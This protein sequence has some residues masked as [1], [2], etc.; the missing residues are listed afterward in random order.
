[1]LAAAS[2]GLSVDF[3]P[4]PRPAGAGVQRAVARAVTDALVQLG[5]F[6]NVQL[7][8]AGSAQALAPELRK[9]PP[10]AALRPRPPRSRAGIPSPVG[11][12]SWRR[13][14]APPS[15][16]RFGLALRG[17]Q[18]PTRRP[19]PRRAAPSEA[20][21]AKIQLRGDKP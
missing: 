6:Q 12:P 16:S 20:A 19:R 1:M 14:P 10:A 18:G 2:Y 7:G 3:S 4:E 21:P 5:A 11:V 8:R 13:Y 17:Q 9:G 15:P